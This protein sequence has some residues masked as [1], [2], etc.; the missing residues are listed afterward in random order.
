M[1]GL[2]VAVVPFSDDDSLATLAVSIIICGS[3][4]NTFN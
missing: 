4:I 1:K 3:G 2:G